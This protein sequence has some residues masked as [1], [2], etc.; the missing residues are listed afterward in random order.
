[1]AFRKPGPDGIRSESLSIIRSMGSQKVKAK[2]DLTACHLN[3]SEDTNVHTSAQSRSLDEQRLI[4]KHPS[5]RLSEAKQTEEAVNSSGSELDVTA[6]AHWDA[7][8]QRARKMVKQPR[9][10]RLVNSRKDQSS[11]FTSW[12]HPASRMNSRKKEF[13]LAS[14]ST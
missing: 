13:S 12:D 5:R 8:R 1:M 14:A 9:K 11:K 2:D 6:V 10:A 7:E 3:P 4:L